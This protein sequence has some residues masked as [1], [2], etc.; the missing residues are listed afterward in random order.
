MTSASEGEQYAHDDSPAGRTDTVAEVID[1]RSTTYGDPVE[2]MIDIAAGW[3]I[4]VGKQIDA[5]TI[6]LMMMWMKMVRAVQSPDYSDHSDDIEGY[7]DIF[8]KV[9]GE[10][11]IHARS[12]TEYLEKKAAR[13]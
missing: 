9:V 5:T 6:P 7:L 4:L 13:P 2:G 8:R 10:D 3:S 12:V 11:M 1:G